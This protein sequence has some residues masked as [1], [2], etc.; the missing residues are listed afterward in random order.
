MSPTRISRATR[1]RSPALAV[2]GAFSGSGSGPKEAG[3]GALDAGSGPSAVS[4]GASPT[5]DSRA[6]TIT[7]IT[8][9]AAV[10]TINA[11]RGKRDPGR[12][13]APSVTS[14]ALALPGIQALQE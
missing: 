7:A 12:A 10:A 3:D 2:A 13:A 6:E 14:S 1:H 8:A 5:G 9:I 4:G 11:A